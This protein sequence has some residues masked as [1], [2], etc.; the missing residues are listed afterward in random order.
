M[1]AFIHNKITVQKEPPEVQY[2]RI[3]QTPQ[4]AQ[5]THKYKKAQSQ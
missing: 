3:P 1:K 2:H 4:Y 5:T